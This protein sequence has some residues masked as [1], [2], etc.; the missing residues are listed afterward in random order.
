MQVVRH[1]DSDKENNCAENLAYGTHLENENDKIGN[2]TWN[3]RNGGAKL[4]PTQVKE[5]R[6]K[7]KTTTQN[8]LAIQYGVSRPTITRIASNKIWKNL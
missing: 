3:L 4:T 1:L 5:I 8:E 6:E 7:L 2:G